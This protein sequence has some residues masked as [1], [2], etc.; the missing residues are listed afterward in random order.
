MWIDD[1]SQLLARAAIKIFVRRTVYKRKLLLCFLVDERVS[2]LCY[3]FIKGFI[4][5]IE[6]QEVFENIWILWSEHWFVQN[7]FGSRLESLSKDFSL[8][9]QFSV[10]RTY[11]FSEAFLYWGFCGI[12]GETISNK[13]KSHT[14]SLRLSYSQLCYWGFC[15]DRIFPNFSLSCPSATQPSSATSD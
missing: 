1:E 12:Q 10:R 3:L 6:I 9:N 7:D 5:L 2:E 15:G 11:A 4:A 8:W 14:R 13:E